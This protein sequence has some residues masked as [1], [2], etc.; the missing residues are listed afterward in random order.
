M[1][2]KCDRS[3]V[4][5]LGAVLAVVL[6]AIVGQVA[7]VVLAGE[8]AE[9]ETRKEADRALTLWYAQ[10]AT[11]WTEALPIGNGRLGTM[12][13]GGVGQEHLQLNEDTLWSGGPHCYDNPDAHRHL[14]AARKAIEQGEFAGAQATAQKMLG[15]PKYQQAYLPLGDL[16]LNFPKSEYPSEYRRELNMRGAVAEVTYRIGGARFT[17]KVFASCPDQAIV[18]RLECD[19]PGRITFDLSMKSP[20]PSKSQTISDDTL[21]MAGRVGPREETRLIGPWKGQGLRFEARVRVAADGGKVVAGGDNISVKDADAAT[22]FYVAATSY[23]NH[24]DI[25]GD[26]TAK[27]EKY[28]AGVKGKSFE[29]LYKSHVDDHA[30]L[31]G[32]VSIDLGGKA[33]AAGPT[34]ERLKRVAEGAADPLLAAQLFQYGRY[35]M[36]AG[37]R[38]G[39]Q[40]LNLQGIWNDKVKPPWGSKYTININIQMNYWVAEVCN[41][42]ECHEPL[43][44]MIGEL[45]EPGAST[46]KVHYKAGGWVAHHNTD[47]WRGTAP[48]DGAQWGMWQTGGAWLCGHLWEHYLYTGDT[49]HLKKS[50]PVL[51]GAAEFFLDFLVENKDG[52]LITSPSLSPE[53]SHGGGVEGGLSLGRRGRGRPQL[54]APGP[55]DLFRPHDGHADLARP[56]RQLHRGIEDIGHRRRIPR[57]TDE[58]AGASRPHED[59]PAR[60]A[61]GMARRLG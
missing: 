22:L 34:D 16:F 18:M 4:A 5:G 53:H 12:V 17:R 31:F 57:K 45:Q 19:K 15:R 50:Y 49:G 23:V 54:G 24:R 27:V 3:K 56:F 13:F 14:A 44:R 48:V 29:Q 20:H 60:P 59:R 10:P 2:A 52:C 7:Q 38:P 40:P 51:K 61:S 25:G 37:S 6:P 32:R 55:H 1:T 36:I 28:L 46:A 26:P 41:L 35:L 11:A 33:A 39:T 58:N 43:L 42:S 8:T 30:E 47:L 21:S 9:N